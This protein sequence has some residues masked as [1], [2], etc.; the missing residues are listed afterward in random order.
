MGIAIKGK[1]FP[2]TDEN[3]MAIIA[4]AAIS[5]ISMIAIP[6]HAKDICLTSVGGLIGFVTRGAMTGKAEEEPKE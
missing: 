5:I 3:K 2:V 4:V 6:E 1:G